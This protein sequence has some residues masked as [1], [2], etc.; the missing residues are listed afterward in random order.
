MATGVKRCFGPNV[1][2][3]VLTLAIVGPGPCELQ[4]LLWASL[5]PKLDTKWA[6]RKAG[7][8]PCAVLFRACKNGLKKG[9]GLEPNAKKKIQNKIKQNKRKEIKKTKSK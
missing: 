5:G 2:A 1:Q 9:L 3:W 4:G 8:G 7:I 6:P